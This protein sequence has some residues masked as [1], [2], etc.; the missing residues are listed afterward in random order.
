MKPIPKPIT[1]AER[2]LL[3]EFKH[4]LMIKILLASDLIYD[5]N[6]A[7]Q[8][9]NVIHQQLQLMLNQTTNDRINYA[10]DVPNILDRVLGGGIAF[11]DVTGFYG[12]I[13]LPADR[14]QLIDDNIE[15]DDFFDD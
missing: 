1:F 5:H 12:S 2:Q 7:V 10:H 4:N 11:D 3:L 15:N 6:R 14:I 13:N 8:H 9:G